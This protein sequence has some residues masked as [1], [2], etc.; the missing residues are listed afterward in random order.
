MCENVTELQQTTDTLLM[1]SPDDFGFNEE[2]AKSNAFQNEMSAS[3][4][5]VM[6]EF[7]SMV[8]TLRMN[9]VRVLVMP[10]R[11]D[12]RTP[13]AVFPN[14]W[15]S[16]HATERPEEKKLVLYPMLAENRRLEI[17]TDNLIGILKREGIKVS[18]T[19][20]LSSY[21]NEYMFLE[22]TGSIILDR[23]NK[24]AY[25]ALSPRSSPAM[26]DIFAERMG[27]KPLTF[28]SFDKNK[29]LIYHTNVMMS[30]GSNFAVVSL[31]SISDATERDA[32]SNQLRTTNKEIVPITL[33]QVANM[34]GNIL[35]VK[36]TD[37][38]AKIVM[39]ETA[40][41]AFTPAQRL[42]LSRY[43]H[44]VPVNIKTIETV[45]G[46]SARCMLAEIF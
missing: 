12:A 10:S 26:I 20:D 46:G 30:V 45:G 23:V 35:E 31:D 5:D 36:S 4:E 24:I 29:Q 13:D 40:Y 28:S 14:N 19:V 39:S 1:V 7:N 22:G 16:V 25:V 21:V 37:G 38:Q 43:G 44:L 41:N 17:Q 3:K 8:E 15:F 32:L 9:S 18:Q 34:A 11:T 6:R 42:T 33:E 2:T 27:Y